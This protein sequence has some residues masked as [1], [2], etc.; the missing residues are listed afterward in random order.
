MKTIEVELQKYSLDIKDPEDNKKYI[1][2]QARCKQLG[3]KLFDC[4]PM[5]NKDTFWDYP[6]VQN[7]ETEILFNNQY[8]TVEGFRIFDWYESIVYHAKNRKNGYYLTGD[9]EQLKAAKENQYI[10][11]Y[12]GKR[13]DKKSAPKFCNACIGS[14]YL[15]EDCLHL[16]FLTPVSDDFNRPKMADPEIVKL[17]ELEKPKLIKRLEEE[18]IQRLITKADKI[19]KETVEK[20][21]SERYESLIQQTLLRSGI[22]TANLIYYSHTKTWCFGWYKELTE[23][24]RQTIYNKLIQIREKLP[25]LFIESIDWKMK[26]DGRG[27]TVQ[28]S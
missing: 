25:D 5:N 28:N 23:P 9:L 10:C 22:D 20:I 27:F 1:A 15:N 3:H 16:L 26:R 14:E 18:K 4:I 19:K 6:I 11:G 8:N 13:Y 17:W 2:I 12:C 24:E 7:I 21:K